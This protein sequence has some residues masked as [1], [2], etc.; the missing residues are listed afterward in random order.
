[1]CSPHILKTEILCVIYM[2]VYKYIHRHILSTDIPIHIPQHM[3]YRTLHVKAQM[4]HY[5]K[6][7]FSYRTVWKTKFHS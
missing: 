3:Y 5:H 2:C 1:M 6:V 4:E 7:T